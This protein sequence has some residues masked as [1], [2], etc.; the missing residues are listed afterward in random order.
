MDSNKIVGERIKSLR[1][2]KSMSIEELAQKAELSVEQIKRIEEDIDLP[3]LSPL[4]KISHALEVRLGTF[5]DD[6]SVV[7]PV[8]CHQNQ[9]E[10]TVM[11]SNNSISSRKNM[12]Y[13]SLSRSKTD[14]HMEPFIID[15]NPIEKEDFVLSTH[16]GEEF[17]YILNGT[18]ELVYGKNKYL[19]N[20]GDSVYYDSIIPHHIHGYQGQKA[21]IL[22][23]IY[24]PV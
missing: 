12:E 24:T 2:S 5:F 8:I 23:V 9:Y 21:K 11:F 19:L 18:M 22:A 17:I 4:I 1:E 7:G 14:R 20:P 10:D 13:H 6:Q 16:E 15:V 3:S